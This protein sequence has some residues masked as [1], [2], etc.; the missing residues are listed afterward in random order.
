MGEFQYFPI[1]PADQDVRLVVAG[2]FEDRV[3][4]LS[5]A[6]VADVGL[7]RLVAGLGEGSDC[8]AGSVALR[9]I[10]GGEEMVIA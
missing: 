10:C 7:D 6:A 2:V 5:V 4:Q 1:M 9:R 3:G 8:Q